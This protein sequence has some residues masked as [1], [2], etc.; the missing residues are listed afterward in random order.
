MKRI[1]VSAGLVAL[2]AVAVHAQYAPGLSYLETSKPWSFTGVIRGFY[3]DNYLTLPKTYPALLPPNNT[4]GFA[5][6]RDSFG[7]EVSPG[8]FYNHSI[9]DTLLSAGY[10]YDLN[11]YQDREGTTDQTHQ[12]NARMDH[13]F[14]ERYKMTVGE[15]FVSAQEPG[16][17]DS[18]VISTPLR[19]A[20][21]NLRNTGTVDFTIQLT[22][23]FDVHVGYAN[24][25]YAYQE[26]AGDEAPANSFAS[27]SALL[28][29]IDQTAA[30]DLRWKALPETT[31]VL[32]Y[33]YEHLDYTSP[34]YITYPG[35]INGFSFPGFRAN[36]R[37][38]DS[39][40]VYLGVDE[41]FT[42]TLNGS[43]RAGG[44]YLYYYNNAMLVFAPT[45]GEFVYVKDATH[46]ISPY[47]DA[48]LTYQYMPQS[49]AQFGI[50]EVH[51][52]TDVPGSAA[53]GAGGTSPVLDEQSTAVYLSVSHRVT[54]RFTASALAQA[55]YSSFN[56]GG[57]TLNGE[58]EDFYTANLNF[59]YHFTP[60]LTGETGYGYSKLNSQL[61]NRSYTRDIV[62]VGVRAT[63]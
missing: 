62:Y 54:S 43:I 25:V 53:P 8:I 15:S 60:W 29:R 35:T 14:S 28:D 26:N 31:G 12:F 52:T 17:L 58:G 63:Y 20:G 23:L 39:S 18:A 36:S 2:G 47:I 37:N 59:A 4:P 56:G 16:V 61:Y 48:S 24:T 30:V 45:P 11:W 50:K 40:Y 32:G 19:V 3:D 38:S 33:Q 13:E 27:Y 49:T 46:S 9:L 21:S 7:V 1:C 44:E 57:S 22:R 41:S 42:P 34:E 51:N 5:H 55:Q 6:S 10:V